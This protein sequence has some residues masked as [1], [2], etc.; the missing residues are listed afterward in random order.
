[1]KRRKGPDNIISLQ[2]VID[3]RIVIYI[4][5]I[6]KVDK[7]TVFHLPEDRNRQQNQTNTYPSSP[8]FAAGFIHRFENNLE[9]IKFIF[10]NR[11]NIAVRRQP[12]PYRRLEAKLIEEAFG[13]YFVG[14]LTSAIV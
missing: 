10:A 6:I 7:L 13:K 12:K 14:Q 2:T 8:V 1:V 3:M 11:N 5:R 4:R 9:L